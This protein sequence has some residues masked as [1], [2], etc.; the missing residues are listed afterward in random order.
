MQSIILAPAH[1]HSIASIAAATS[2]D[3]MTPILEHIQITVDAGAV[4]ALATDRYRA[5]RVQFDLPTDEKTGEV[6]TLEPV[7]IPAALLVAFS[8]ALKAAKVGPALDVT[9]TVDESRVTLA[10]L[11]GVQLAGDTS[12]QNFPPV[13]RLIDGYKPGDVRD[14]I[15]RPDFMADAS[16]FMLPSDPTAAAAKLAGWGMQFSYASAHKPGPVLLS[17]SEGGAGTGRIQYMLQPNL[18]LS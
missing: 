1:I 17:R 15:L 18:K 3:S 5:A 16:K 7:A 8:K 12:A 4:T 9:L 10:H 13:G 2:K 14:V 11:S 6:A